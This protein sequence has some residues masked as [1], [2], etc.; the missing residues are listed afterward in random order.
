MDYSLS[1]K[2][3]SRKPAN[4]VSQLSSGS[5]PVVLSAAAIIAILLAVLSTNLLNLNNPFLP[6]S[7]TTVL[8]SKAE[9]PLPLSGSSKKTSVLLSY[10]DTKYLPDTQ[11]SSDLKSSTNPDPLMPTIM[12]QSSENQLEMS[13]QYALEHPDTLAGDNQ[14]SISE[15][16]FLEPHIAGQEYLWSGSSRQVLYYLEGSPI[17]IA[18]TLDVTPEES[19]SEDGLLSP[20]STASSLFRI[21]LGLNMADQPAP[22]LKN[23]I[24][25][26]MEDSYHSQLYETRL[27]NACG[28]AATLIVL[29]YYGLE[30]SINN[31]I[32]LM[33]VPEPQD[34]G[35]DP[36]CLSN[37]VCTSPKT[38]ARVF[39]DE[40]GLI[41][42]TRSHWTLEDVHEALSRGN[43][44]IADIR[45]FQSGGTL[46]HFVVI[47]G[48]DMETQTLTYHD[49]Y[50]GAA[51]TSSWEQFSTRWSGPVDVYDPLQPEGF[52]FWGME[53]YPPP[54]S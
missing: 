6:L 10:S 53:I 47:Y 54:A 28:P 37:P 45:W 12:L 40:Y 17:R 32:R 42:H 31:V 1:R 20:A 41:V 48:I 49:P 52:I 23:T 38:M 36:A 7:Q 2:M 16:A 5:W 13:Y 24:M 46:G 51:R 11:N 9:N 43:P 25:L 27:P 8:A 18:L 22:A 44:I 30:E 14:P 3:V 15:L 34:G 19:G 26:P 39:S 21:H 4:I 50:T 33:Q 35:Y 29:D